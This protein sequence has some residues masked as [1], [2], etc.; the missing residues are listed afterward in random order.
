M[1]SDA[2][3]SDAERFYR[4][5]CCCSF[6][7]RQEEG[8]QDSSGRVLLTDL[9]AWA[10]S[11]IRFCLKK[12]VAHVRKKKCCVRLCQLESALEDGLVSICI[13]ASG[14]TWCCSI[15]TVLQKPHSLGAFF[16]GVSQCT[17]KPKGPQTDNGTA[18]D[19]IHHMSHHI[20]SVCSVTI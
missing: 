12:L 18:L 14:C 10:E 2:S 19:S 16:S 15:G 6:A 4:Q 5:T 9:F 3:S 20:S 7:L 11:V 1:E 13:T 17:V 8:S